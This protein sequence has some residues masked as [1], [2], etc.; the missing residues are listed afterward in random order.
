MNWFKRKPKKVSTPW[1]GK[2]DLKYVRHA[3]FFGD[4]PQEY[5]TGWPWKC[6]CGNGSPALH[7]R[8]PFTEAEAVAEF[9]AHR[10]LYDA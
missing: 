10:D 3:E 6:S 7:L 5:T 8:W 4:S 1:N 2:H 9:R